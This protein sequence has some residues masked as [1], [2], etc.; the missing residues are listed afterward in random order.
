MENNIVVK[1]GNRFWKVVGI[2]LA[3]AGVCFVAVKVYNKFFRKA[4][5]VVE[6]KEEAPAVEEAPVVE[7]T[8]AVEEAPAQEDNASKGKKKSR[9]DAFLDKVAPEKRSLFSRL[10]GKK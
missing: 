5:P 8:P 1:K 10:F 7:E 4:Q 6:G 3:I 2:L 9:E